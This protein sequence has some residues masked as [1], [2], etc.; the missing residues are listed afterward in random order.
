MEVECHAHIKDPEECRRRGLDIED[1]DCIYVGP[2]CN[3]PPRWVF[4]V[5]GGKTKAYWCDW[6]KPAGEDFV[7][8]Y[9]DS[10]GKRG[11]QMYQ[12]K[13]LEEEVEE[14][15]VLPSPKKRTRKGRTQ[16]WKISTLL[17]EIKDHPRYQKL[18]KRYHLIIEDCAPPT[19]GD[20][21]SKIKSKRELTENHQFL[22]SMWKHLYLDEEFPV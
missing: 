6:C 9:R 3:Q 1:K 8:F 17:E 12:L 10:P 4:E 14:E 2:R 18:D 15:E 7:R 11:R 22:R 13:R 19:E 5:D 20:V 21:L 16:P